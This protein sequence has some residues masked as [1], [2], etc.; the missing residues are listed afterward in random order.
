MLLLCNPTNKL[1]PMVDICISFDLEMGVLFCL[2]KSNCLAIYPDIIHLPSSFQLG[3]DS[4][5]WSNKLCYLDVLITVNSK[6]FFDLKIKLV[7]FMQQFIWLL[8]TVV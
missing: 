4:L 5:N 6:N 8:L 1:Q 3:G 2:L 7:N